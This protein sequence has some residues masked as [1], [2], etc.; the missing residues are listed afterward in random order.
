MIR[1][2]L[3]LA[4]SATIPAANYLIG[5][6]GTECVPQG[7]C[8]VPVGLGLMAPSGVLMIGLALVL[9]DALHEA[10]GW[11]WATCAV[12]AGAVLSLLFSPPSIALASAIAFGVAEIADMLIYTP[13]RKRGR[14][15]AVAASGVI[16]SVVDSVLF[17]LIAFGSV[18][19]AAGTAIAK[20]YAS[21]AV[22]LFLY[23]RRRP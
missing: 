17:V 10:A 12:L 16:G 5:H 2:A 6:V 23:A 7:P 15:M 4:F 3:F 18:E 22:A 19:F 13:L 20:M 11:K 8:L 21:A 1:Y 14:A 9:R